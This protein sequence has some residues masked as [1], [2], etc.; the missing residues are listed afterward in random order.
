MVISGLGMVTPLGATPE[1]T[2]S[3]LLQGKSACRPL[4]PADHAALLPGVPDDLWP[5]AVNGAACVV[6]VSNGGSEGH[7]RA[8]QL[9]HAAAHAAW[10][11]ARLTSRRVPA[12]RIGCVIGSSKGSFASLTTC[13][14]R[15]PSHS[16]SAHSSPAGFDWEWCFPSAAGASV[17]R[18]LGCRGP[19]LSP[20]AACAT[21]LV[22][23]IRAAE[24]IARGVCDV[25]VVGSVDTSLHPLLLASF[26]KLGVLARKHGGNDGLCRPFDH[27]RNGFVVGEGAAILV[28]ERADLAQSRGVQPYAEW[29]SGGLAGDPGGMTSVTADGIGTARLIQ[30]VLADARLTTADIG[31]IN[32]HGTGTI[33][34]DAAESRAVQRAFGESAMTAAGSSCKGAI[35]HLL[36][37]AGSVELALTAMAVREQTAPPTTGLDQAATDCP[38]NYLPGIGR[39]RDI[40]AALKLSLGFGGHIAAAVLRRVD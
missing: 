1:S 39:Q 27:R 5:N 24:L 22:C 26:Q 9:L 19:L 35:G 38:L 11:D 17:A 10:Q 3:A 13:W 8:E 20:V 14:S 36:G 33:L 40:P 15:D 4:T 25:V 18:L 30:Q 6:P 2:W 16:D 31:Y 23:A 21:G 7:C 34:N 29:G 28:L 32:Y 12:D 37:A